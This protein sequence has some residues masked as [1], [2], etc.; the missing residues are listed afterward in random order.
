MKWERSWHQPRCVLRIWLCL[1]SWGANMFC[2]TITLTFTSVIILHLYICYQIINLN[3]RFPNYII[4][5]WDLFSI[6]LV[7]VVYSCD[8]VTADGP[9]LITLFFRDQHEITS[10]SEKFEKRLRSGNWRVWNVRNY[11]V[12]GHMNMTERCYVYRNG[13]EIINSKL[14]SKSLIIWMLKKGASINSW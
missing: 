4:S 8:S 9:I 10:M 12:S 1:R 6:I 13:V 3:F 2:L 5:Q 7:Y 14:F 11:G